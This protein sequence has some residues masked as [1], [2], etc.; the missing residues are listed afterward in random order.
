LGSR[1]PR[2]LQ[3]KYWLAYAL[4][5]QGKGAE[6][7]QLLRTLLATAESQPSTQVDERVL[8]VIVPRI[9]QLISRLLV[10]SG[11]TRDALSMADTALERM[12]K[13]LPPGHPEI[14]DANQE[15]ASKLAF[16]NQLPSAMK[17]ARE[18]LESC[19]RYLGTEHEISCM[20]A[21]TYAHF[22]LSS[23]NPAEGDEELVWAIPAMQRI[24]G[25]EH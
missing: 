1:S 16:S 24:V 15:R 11:N 13:L 10:L 12:T 21:H 20:A 14:L 25:S 8:Q 19:K 9:M 22:C 2:T 5:E 7:L 4:H 17:L 23:Q 3:A 18:T 6:A